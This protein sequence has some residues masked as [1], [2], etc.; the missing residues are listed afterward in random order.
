ME[1]DRTKYPKLRSDLKI[2]KAVRQDKITYVVKDPLKEQFYKFAKEEWAIIELFTGDLSVEEMAIKYN[3]AHLGKEID[4]ETVKS[5][6]GSLEEMK[7]LEKDKSEQNVMLIEK[8]KE[9]RKGQLL[10]KKGSIFYKRFPI[11]DPDQFFNR[12][13]PKITF[14]WSKTFVIFSLT[15]MLTAIMMIIYRFNEF[16]MGVYQLFSFHEMSFLNLAILWVIIYVTI[17]IHEIGHGL[18]CKYYGGDVHEIGFLLLF[19]QPCMYCNVND[20]W[21]FDKKWKQI[22]VTIAGGYIEFFIGSIFTFIWFFTNPNTFINI[23]SFQVMTICSASTVLFNFNPLMKLDGYYLLADALEVAN[24]KENSLSYFKHIVVTKIFKMPSSEEDSY[25]PRE[26][27]ILL[28]YGIASFFYTIGLLTGLFFM[29]QNLLLTKSNWYIATTISG[30]V[31]YKLFFDHIKSAATFLFKFYLK[32]KELIMQDKSKKRLAIVATLLLLS[33]FIPIPYKIYGDC[34]LEGSDL[35]LVR[36]QSEGVLKKFMVHDGAIVSAQAP[37]LE[38]E[39]ETLKKELEIAKLDL[40]K[41]QIHLRQALQDDPSKILSA[42]EDVLNK[43]LKTKEKQQQVD[44]LLIRAI[45]I[46]NNHLLFSCDKEIEQI[47]KF[48]NKGDEVAKLQSI[49]TLKTVINISEQQ[50]RFLNLHNEVHFKLI[51]KPFNTFT[52]YVSKVRQLGVKDSKN[53]TQKNYLAELTILN[54]SGDSLDILRPGM[55]GK[56]KIYADKVLLVQYF[57]IKSLEFLR[58][59]L[60]I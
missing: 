40:Q 49:A 23:I 17:A 30:L 58:I 44:N 10:S 47:N 41:T 27:K 35:L 3:S 46:N 26:K 12:I 39:N 32:H 5:F 48:F 33:L 21:L 43:T 54:T 18:T 22:A 53:P 19:F 16:S 11:V 29:V 2:S 1:K 45:G 28:S 57:F 56:A 7:L 24:L 34:E 9:L 60:L 38:L 13:I 15:L 37:L 6:Q 25:S 20:A 55:K 4:T 14:F 51:S 50:I 52:G 36:A 8:M 59:D 42:R 31:A